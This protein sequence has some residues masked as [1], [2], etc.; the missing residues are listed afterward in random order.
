MDITPTVYLTS[1]V[2]LEISSNPKIN[3]E[4]REKIKTL[5]N[6]LEEISNLHYFEGRFPDKKT[7]RQTLERIKPHIVGCHLSHPITQHLL[8][9]SQIVAV[10]TATA[11]Y[12]HI[13]RLEEDRI[14]VTHTPGVLHH[15][16]ADYTIAIIMANLRNIVDLHNYVW[17]G[18][19]T[20]DDKWDLDQSLSS[21]IDNKTIGI[22]GLGEIGTEVV[23]R[24]HP[25]GLK[26]IYYDK[27]R[28][29]HT[30]EEFPGLECKASLEEVFQEAD[31]VSLHIPL[32]KYT[33]GIIDEKLLRLMKK[34]ALL[35]NTSRGGILNF[36]DLL[37]LLENK[38][39]EINFSFD[40]FPEEPVDPQILKH[41]KRIKEK[42]PHIRMVLM[43]HNASADADTRGKMVILFL[44]DLIRLVRS[45][46]LEDLMEAHIIPEHQR[47]LKDTKWKIQ[48]YWSA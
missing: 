39:I 16:V 24:L 10:C 28:C 27:N 32:N 6:H 30:E 8:Q 38:E 11:G 4:I 17:N 29:R 1:N 19:W 41:L 44:E 43:P 2:F 23:R 13:K 26:I 14:L 35:V 31:I 25:W 22:M 45:D 5:W 37:R 33:K 47:K 15:T 36:E 40:V 12:N 3:K 42:R 20:A 18:N 21:V 48:Q 7:L 34:G 46:S 9:D